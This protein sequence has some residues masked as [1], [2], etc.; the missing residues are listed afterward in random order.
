MEN[1]L[2]LQSLVFLI[3]HVVVDDTSLVLVL[4][5]VDL[6]GLLGAGV[7]T[8]G[9]LALGHAKVLKLFGTVEHGAHHDLTCQR[10]ACGVHLTEHNGLLL[11]R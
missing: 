4:V 9:L 3:V 7:D 1:Q 6:I 8:L 5:L 11:A 10:E 2:L